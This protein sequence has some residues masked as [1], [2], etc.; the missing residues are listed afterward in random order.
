MGQ[1]FTDYG[2]VIAHEAPLG[3]FLPSPPFFVLLL[4]TQCI[5]VLI[6]IFR[7][8]T[9]LEPIKGRLDPSNDETL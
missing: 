9:G 4:L 7:E 8:C 5:I 1:L 6:R 3:L 2:A